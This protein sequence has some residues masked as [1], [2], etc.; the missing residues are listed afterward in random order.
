[1][2]NECEGSIELEWGRYS[3]RE[4]EKICFQYIK[5]IYSSPFYNVKLTHPGNDGGRDIIIR[6]LKTGF[7]AW[8]ECKNH[9]RNID[10]SI[11]GKNVV[12][13]LSH[14]INKA[15]FFS[16]TPIT[17]NTKV[18][19]LKLSQF[20]NFDVLFLD[21]D[22][23]NKEILAC[24]SVAIKYF[25]K[26]YA[27]YNYLGSNK[28]YIDSFLSEFQHAEGTDY[29][30]KKLYHLNNGFE[31]FLHVF[32]RNM[33]SIP[34]NAGQIILQN[35][36]DTA[37]IFYNPIINLEAPINAYS[38]RLF[39][40]PGLVLLPDKKISL[41]NLYCK[42]VDNS[43]LI[44]TQSINNGTIDA[45]DVWR[46][47][48][49]N[50]NSSLFLAEIYNEIKN[51]IPKGFSRVFFISGK[52]GSGKSRLITEI[53][54][55]ALE[56]N[57]KIIHIDFSTYTDLDAIRVIF[58]KWYNLPSLEKN[59]H[60]E[61]E[62]FYNAVSDKDIDETSLHIL[63]NFL[64]LDGGFTNPKQFEY[65]L[66]MKRLD[67]N[68]LISFDNIQETS[69][70]MQ[71]FLWHITSACQAKQI[72]ICF[73][74]VL[75]TEKQLINDNYLASYLSNM[76]KNGTENHLHSYIC[77]P[78]TQ[79]DAISIIMELLH[80]SYDTE[81]YIRRVVDSIGTL[82]LNLLFF[83]KSISREKS[84]FKQVNGNLYI[85][86]PELLQ[87]RTE[88]FLYSN[89]SSYSTSAFIYSHY[90]DYRA[91]FHMIVLFDGNMPGVLFFEL[92]YSEE[93]LYELCDNL[94]LKCDVIHN[95]IHFYNDQ[96][97]FYLQ[98][99]PVIMHA[100]YYEKVLHFYNNRLLKGQE[101]SIT[102]SKAY[103]KSL[104]S[105]GRIDCA[106]EHGSKLLQIAKKSNLNKDVC[107]ICTLLCSLYNAN[108]DPV[109]YVLYSL[110]K[111]DYLLERVNISKAEEIYEYI[112]RTID[113]NIPLFNAETIIHFYHRY[114]N[115]KIH[116]GQY[117]KAIDIINEFE[118]RLSMSDIAFYIIHDRYC[119]AYTNIGDL[120]NALYHINLVIEKA[121]KLAN[122]TWLS[123]AY[124]DK[125]FAYYY[126]C[127]E[128][129]KIIESFRE[130]VNTHEQNNHS[131]ISISREIEIFIQKS[132][133]LVLEENLTE[134]ESTII[135]AIE[136][137]E[138]ADY[139]YLLVPAYNVWAYI[140]SCKKNFE[141][142]IS[143][144][145]KA[146]M[147]ATIFVNQKALISVYN[148][149]GVIYYLSE[150]NIEGLS[151][152]ILAKE[153]LQT[154]FK[155]LIHDPRY[156]GLL[157]NLREASKLSFTSHSIPLK[158]NSY[159]FLYY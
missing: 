71:L 154:H 122:M 51:V 50:S 74:Y 86:N 88:E 151:N 115:Q 24:R 9:K 76:G 67:D 149:L 132:L 150:N 93:L 94:I 107:E 84:I 123:I 65:L 73:V 8:G 7:E 4:F 58:I 10:L 152:L 75:N 130:A 99:Q 27:K 6:N 66:L 116:T 111:A 36:F 143:V 61:F 85:V 30:Y 60:L 133:Y 46:A 23:L 126:N 13:A 11:I 41:P 142:A 131:D 47:P 138:K 31:I 21:G 83:G 20:H 103:F 158:L 17:Y 128:T 82:P 97:L 45:S 140:L 112:K 137:A 56:F 96:V 155:W 144:M 108:T 72:P 40:F 70:N 98:K 141:H 114:I 38:E 89:N 35:S 63:Y 145:R 33:R 57:Y 14:K 34:I 135:K 118:N 19:I 3:W 113:N 69:P 26:E 100:D 15:I 139:S 28:I 91:L 81:K 153:I 52:S 59:N 109:E 102:L 147:C 101:I 136:K 68:L 119:V 148:N 42:L 80:L 22:R 117:N 129:T 64:Y 125:A 5:C 39:T 120:S 79:E 44:Y 29:S 54:N 105:L 146:F 49:I 157:C 25:K 2:D 43:G 18:E 110:I 12:L 127:Q 106:K 124:S 95:S 1:M 134:A 77:K 78:L 32:V 48:Y 53:E 121:S 92:N 62:A 16:V 55:K 90:T 104:I 37:Y 87:K 156:I 159:Y